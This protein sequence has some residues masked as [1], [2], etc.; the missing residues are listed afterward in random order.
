MPQFAGL[1]R[2]SLVECDDVIDLAPLSEVTTVVLNRCNNV[3]DLRPLAGVRVLTVEWCLNVT[4]VAGLNKL[5]E[6][7][8]ERLPK[9]R[10][11]RT[12][13]A[14]PANTRHGTC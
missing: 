1:D 4:H 8:M 14:G 6:L 10:G 3:V 13:T 5:T 7:T 12:R 11:W 2:L 9:V